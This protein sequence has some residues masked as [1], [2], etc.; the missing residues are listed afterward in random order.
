MSDTSFIQ[1]GK[2]LKKMVKKVDE[3]GDEYVVPTKEWTAFRKARLTE[4]RLAQSGIPGYVSGFDLS[5]IL[6]EDEHKRKL[7]IFVNKFDEKFSKTHLYFWSQGNG[8][9]KTTTASIVCKLLIEKKKT[10]RFVLMSELVNTLMN[11]QF[12]DDLETKIFDWLNCDFL[13]IDDSFDPKKL[14][15]YKSGYQLPFLDTFLRKRLEIL[16]KST[17]FTSNIPIGS[18]DEKVFGLSIKKL[19]KRSVPDPFHFSVVYE[20]QCN[21]FDI[22]ELWS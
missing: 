9:Q 18:I 7:E 10:V 11:E 22:D 17:C 21:D 3:F 8:T 14:T 4:I 1:D 5:S 12:E 20:E 15:V 13:V 6:E 19:V 16:R 2:R